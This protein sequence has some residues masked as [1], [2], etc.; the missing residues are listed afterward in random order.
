MLLKE[1]QKTVV[2]ALTG[3]SIQ[4]VNDSPFGNI[5]VLGIHDSGCLADQDGHGHR[6]VVLTAQ[7]LDG[8]LGQVA[9][10]SFV[11]LL[12]WPY[13]VT[14]SGFYARSETRASP[15]LAARLTANGPRT[16]EL[17]LNLDDNPRLEEIAQYPV[18]AEALE[19]TGGDV[20][21][22]AKPDIIA[23]CPSSRGEALFLLHITLQTEQNGASLSGG[24]TAGF[25]DPTTRPPPPGFGRKRH[26]IYVDD[27]DNDGVEDILLLFG[28]V[29]DEN[30]DEPPP[31]VL[32]TALDVYYM[33]RQHQ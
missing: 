2:Y 5:K 11:E 3:S 24:M 18:F 23:L 10:H 26:G 31:A 30:Q 14:S 1:D 28:I 19:L 16:G 6:A 22:D 25:L 8:P 9:V 12:H 21:G 27:L 33:G 13:P 7:G 15:V 32:V 4:P 17:L 29:I 20:D